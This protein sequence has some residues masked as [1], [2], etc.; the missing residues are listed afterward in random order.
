MAEPLSIDG[1]YGEGGGQI[2]RTAL[3]LA[4]LLG[5]PVTI[6][7]IRANRPKPGLRPQHLR[8]VRALAEITAA[9]LQGDRENSTRLTFMPQK[10]RGGT[11]RFD[12]GTAGACTLLVAAVLPPLLFAPEPSEVVI[13]GGTHVPFSPPYHYFAEVFLPVIA[14]MGGKVESK[15]GRWGW[16]P[17]GGGEIKLQITPCRRL[18]AMRLEERGE[19]QSLQLLIGLTNLPAHIA[20][21]EE[22][23]LQRQLTA[24]G[25]RLESRLVTPTSAGQGN[26]LFLK[27]AFARTVV[28]FSA[29]G[30]RG[31]PAEQVA[32]EVGHAWLTFVQSRAAVDLH[33]ADQLIPYMALADGDS[34]LVTEQLS[35][36]L[37]TNIRVVEQFLPVRFEVDE[38]ELRVQV[39][40]CGHMADGPEI[41]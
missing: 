9:G 20:G 39:R 2:L 25:Y 36:H 7:H 30:R 41:T 21:R 40:G 4:A 1:S 38:K 34:S 19:L 32:G 17:A 22:E 33:L 12:I 37:L 18:K 13:T 26:G 28:A 16:Y 15:L 8:A 31:V 23:T 29:L 27:A 11:F 35:G 5:R 24:S 3:A 14:A 10:L 6:D